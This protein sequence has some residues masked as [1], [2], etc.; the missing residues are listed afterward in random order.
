M[1][2]LSFKS[3]P[4]S[5]SGGAGARRG[6]IRAGRRGRV[7]RRRTAAAPDAETQAESR[8]EFD[9]DVSAFLSDASFW[10]P[11]HTVKPPSQSIFYPVVSWLAEAA[12]P[13][14]V[15]AFGG[16]EPGLRPALRDAVVRLGLKTTCV[17]V[18][19]FED[20]GADRAGFEASFPKDWEIRPRQFREFA[21]FER[22]SIE[23]IIEAFPDRSIDWIQPAEF[24]G[25]D[26]F[27][28]DLE[29]W[30]PKLSPRA[31][32][33]VPRA[34]VWEKKGGAR[35]FLEEISRHHPSFLFDHGDGLGLVGL[36]SAPSARVQA[37][38]DAD[39]IPE[40]RDAIRAAYSR[41]G[42]GL[43]EAADADQE[44]RVGALGHGPAIL[45]LGGTARSMVSRDSIESPDGG[46]DASDIEAMTLRG[47]NDLL[48]EEN[49]RL[50]GELD[51]LGEQSDALRRE[52]PELR[53]RAERFEHLHAA[54]SWQLHELRQSAALALIEKSQR[55]RHRLFPQ[56]RLHGRCA[57]LAAR[58]ARDSI[59]IGPHV[60]VR[61]AA[62]RVLRK[63]GLAARP[64]AT[65]SSRGQTPVY[66]ALGS[67]GAGAR[68]EDLPWT[69][70]GKRAA[71]DD[72]GAPTL[73]ILLVGHSACRTGAPHC[74][75]RLSEGLAKIPGVECWTVL[76]SGG[77]LSP[78]FARHAPTMEL[79][80][81]EAR[82][83]AR[84]DGP[85]EIAARLQAYSRNVV[86]VCN[87]M[88]VGE[89]HEAFEAAGIPVI[90]WIHELPTF[91]DIL[92][93]REAIDRIQSASLRTIVP[94]NVVRE[95]LVERFD[96]DRS[97]VQTVYN[98][99]DAKG[100]DLSREASRAKVREEL[101]LPADARIVLGCGTI[102]LR[103]GVD[104]FAQLG[105]TFLREA[106]PADLA[107]KT[108]FVWVGH[109]SDPDLLKWLRHDLETAG[110]ADRVLFPGSRPDMAP[111]FLA[112]DLFALTSRE[113]PCPFANLEAMESALAVVA[114][115]DSGGAPEVLGEG[116]I[117]A[118]Y[119]DVRAMA[120]AVR[121]LLTDDRKRTEMGR[122]GQASIRNHFTWPR[123]MT[124][125]REI[126]ESECG[127]GRTDRPTVSVIL[128]N[129]NHAGFL[130]ARLR[131]IFEQTVAPLEIIYLD[132][133]STDDSVEVVRRLAPESPAPLRIIVN[134]RNNNSTFL[135]WLKGFELAQGDLIWI[136]ESDD[137]AHPQFLE[138]LL[139][140][141]ADPEV[142]LAYSQSALIDSDDRLLAE[143]FLDHTDGVSTTRWRSRYVASGEE[144]AELAL[145]QKNTIPNA[146][147]AVF[148]R[149]D[150]STIKAELSEMRFAGDWLFYATRAKEGKI[151]F[152]P[153]SLNFYRRHVKTV[154]H[155]SFLTDTHAEE[156]LYVK[157]RV[158]ETFD[159][160]LNAMSR[161]LC[162]TF[163]DHAMIARRF[164]VDRPTL[165]KERRPAITGLLD[166]ARAALHRR[167]DDHEGLKTLF[168]LEK[169][170]DDADGL[171]S[172]HLINALARD[173]RVYL[174]V[175]TPSAEAEAL[176]ERLDDR[177]V[178]I[179]GTLGVTPW[180]SMTPEGCLRAEVLQELVRFHGVDVIHSQPGEADR[181]AAQI[182]ADLKLPWLIHLG[183]GEGRWLGDSADPERAE[184]L[185]TVSGVFHEAADPSDLIKTRPEFGGKRWVRALHGLDPDALPEPTATIH[186]REG[187]VWV[188]L[189]T[190]ES[191]SAE[192]LKTAM[193]AIRIVNRLPSTERGGL[194]A[195]L[196]EAGPGLGEWELMA[197]C[198]LAIA[199]HAGASRGVSARIAA[200]LAHRIPIIAPDRG[201]V[202][203]MLA[204]D[205]G[206]VGLTVE[207][208]GRSTVSADR[209]AA[210]ILRSLKRPD[211]HVDHREAAGRL[212]D[213]R[214]HVE[215]TSAVVGE[216]YLRARDLLI[217]TRAVGPEPR[218][219]SRPAGG[220]AS[221]ESA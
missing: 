45:G 7:G 131:S 156:T 104:L 162:Q 30:R 99:L 54:A 49:E 40:V 123:F 28:R 90:S 61:K 22:G 204:T 44:R 109:P 175:A 107:S 17:L 53:Y 4:G 121:E 122:R 1:K 101:D 158:F 38:F 193:D 146:S 137:C 140:E 111:Y 129:F 165:T 207:S 56:T 196:V 36:G 208:D 185:A 203:D 26:C 68:F 21:R 134:E 46:P 41:L 217:F 73:K 152:L 119:L 183:D 59:K 179:E 8:S 81:L 63:V 16:R 213:E 113:D 76:K 112:A 124:E 69:F 180:S 48:R 12:K 182:N 18:E 67:P 72:S 160:S 20:T 14:S 192:E 88:T 85:A 25:A 116:G 205:A 170:G 6:G 168:I 23:R 133:A 155:R 187:E 128:P 210:A 177:V 202:H 151:A 32:L 92:G 74:L 126:L 27:Q 39:K 219:E 189:V 159:I 132:N 34:G 78:Q 201:A 93:G 181:L 141:F 147:A 42:R 150:A 117:V 103:K 84:A 166:R 47:E 105:R 211:L 194:R 97:R 136:A 214:F 184:A 51:R 79:A 9:M 52:N 190:E 11:V 209:L 143:N 66:R 24:Y 19:P 89:F 95:A 144:E 138:R 135:Q 80:A 33:L 58:F 15:L 55:L 71:V 154:S 70:T 5:R 50:T 173:H 64:T 199:P 31:M 172:L 43:A 102:D 153:D 2:V 37:L 35:G 148:R 13:A 77:E 139:P 96:F 221:R 167:L 130:E 57:E 10:I 115:Q 29:A 161:G 62:G 125:F 178:L 142:V 163:L 186:K 60:A 157:V 108:Y 215:R 169:A 87:T 191:R 171:A 212:F 176:A 75:L 86:A 118:P 94:A 83:F 65:P 174:C 164:H 145:S 200:L 100:R 206:S 220:T 127:L 3:G 218:T 195:R 110:L 188:Y 82:G 114:F 120:E 91:I 198:D 216:A 149:P 106:A 197:H 98:G